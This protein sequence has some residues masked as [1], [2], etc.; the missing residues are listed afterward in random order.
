[1]VGA[2]RDEGDSLDHLSIASP[3]LYVRT[4]V[5]LRNNGWSRTLFPPH[6]Y[7]N[8]GGS[9]CENFYLILLEN[10]ENLCKNIDIHINLFS[11]GVIV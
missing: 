2:R 9:G 4:R 5:R 7:L 8:E 6:P 11:K 3:G 10:E 1:M